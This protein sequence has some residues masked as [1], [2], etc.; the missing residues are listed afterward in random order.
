MLGAADFYTPVTA[1]VQTDGRDQHCAVIVWCLVLLAF[2]AY[3]VS[4]FLQA[5]R[6]RRYVGFRM[7][8]WEGVGEGR[9]FERP[10]E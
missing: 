9:G 3:T 8:D 5:V 6:E 10:L 2:L 7:P 1:V 4:V